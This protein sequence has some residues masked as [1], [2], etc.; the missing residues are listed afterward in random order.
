MIL[1]D[2]VPKTIISVPYEHIVILM[3]DLFLVQLPKRVCNSWRY[4][5]VDMPHY[6]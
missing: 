5:A 3:F 6:D 1:K 4:P 2:Y